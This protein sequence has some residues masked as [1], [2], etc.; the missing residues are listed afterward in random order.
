[1]SGVEDATHRLS[2]FF[3]KFKTADGQWH[4]PTDLQLVSGLGISAAIKGG[5]VEAS[6]AKDSS[7]VPSLRWNM[8]MTCDAVANVAAINITLLNTA[9]IVSEVLVGGPR[10]EK[11]AEVTVINH[12]RL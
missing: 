7:Y 6:A 2:H 3:I 8:Q 9:A 12:P 11:F 10:E 5:E 4:E 1:M